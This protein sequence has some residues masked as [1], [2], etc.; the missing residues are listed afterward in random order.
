MVSRCRKPGNCIFLGIPRCGCRC[1]G[2]APRRGARIPA[3][4]GT[5]RGG[6]LVR[7]DSRCSRTVGVAGSEWR[8]SQ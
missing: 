4:A 3:G 2:E 6:A 8:G 7:R 1:P 5:R